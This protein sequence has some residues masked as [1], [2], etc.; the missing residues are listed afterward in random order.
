VDYGRPSARGRRV[1][2]A[3][4]VLGD[5]IWRTG[6]NAATQ[7]RTSAPLTIAGQTIPAGMYTLWTL[8]VPGRYQLIVNKQVGQWGTEYKRDQDLARVPLQ[9]SRLAQPLDRFTIAVDPTGGNTGVLKLR[10]DTTE[11]AVPFT[12]SS[13]SP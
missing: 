2:G 12:V 9:V 3:N 6:A 4:G 5:T 11:L 8:A 7:F 13:P 10:W 1:F